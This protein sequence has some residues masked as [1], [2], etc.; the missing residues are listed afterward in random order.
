MAAGFLGFPNG[1]LAS[2]AC[3]MTVHTDNTAY[4]CG[5]EG[6]IQIPIPWKPPSDEAIY[7]VAS[8]TPPRMDQ[9]GKATAALP[10]SQPRDVRKVPVGGVLYGIE[11]DDFA[12]TV[13]D[14]HAPRLTAADSIG[15]MRVLDE[16]RR[17]VGVKF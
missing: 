1:M 11:A 9:G 3:G 14:G 4:L 13:I 17:Q 16:L 10:G 8:S 2:F 15:N 6:Y 12:A 5:S 7:I